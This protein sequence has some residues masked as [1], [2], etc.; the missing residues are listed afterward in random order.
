MGCRG[1]CESE[2]VG[3]RGECESAS[4]WGAGEN[5]RVPVCVWGGGGVVH[6]GWGWPYIPVSP[7][8]LF[9]TVGQRSYNNKCSR[10]RAGE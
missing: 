10:E 5:V 1:E 3:C 6:V 4:V 2:C 9:F 7:P 8:P